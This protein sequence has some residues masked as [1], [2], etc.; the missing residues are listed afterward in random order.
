[1]YKK[2][3]AL[4][5]CSFFSLFANTH[6]KNKEP[7]LV[8]KLEDI[9]TIKYY[10]LSSNHSTTPYILWIATPKEEM[11]KSGFSAVFFL[12]GNAIAND[13]KRDDVAYLQ[14]KPV[15]VG[16]GYRVN[17]RFA[18]DERAYDFTPK[19]E[20]TND[21]LKPTRKNGG[22][23]EFLNFITDKIIPTVKREVNIDGSKMA[24]WGQSYGGLFTLYT[25]FTKPETFSHYIV[26]DPSLWWRE[27]EILKIEQNTTVSS[28]KNIT[29]FKSS[30][31][32]DE[33]PASSKNIDENTLKKIKST[34]GFFPSDEIYR[35]S[36]RLAKVHESVT[37]A[38]FSNETHGSLFINSIKPA[39]FLFSK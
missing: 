35:L 29:F 21:P 24:L 28:K 30:K 2:I 14:N 26:I 18:V 31:Q 7:S 23:E 1:M 38:E 20:F 15:M 3:V 8:E 11:P 22:A 34:Q 9:Y 6:E 33:P 37:Y 39:L 27:G 36:L 19:T 32:N 10:K 5:F 12:D 4:L 25:L 13:I 17:A 16:I